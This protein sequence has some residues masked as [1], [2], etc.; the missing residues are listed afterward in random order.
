VSD[1]SFEV[2][3]RILG[4]SVTQHFILTFEEPNVTVHFVDTDGRKADVHG[5]AD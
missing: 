1:S 3:R 5:S 2:E 4:G